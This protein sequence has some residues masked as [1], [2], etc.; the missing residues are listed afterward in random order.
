M[1]IPISNYLATLSTGY[2]QVRDPINVLSGQYTPVHG[3]IYQEE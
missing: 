2:P 3:Y 1:S